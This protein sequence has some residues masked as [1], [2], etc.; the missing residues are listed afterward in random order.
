[1]LDGETDGDTS[2]DLDDLEAARDQDDI[3]RVDNIHKTYLLG[4]EGVAALR[5]VSMSVRRGEFV[6]LYGTS[7][8]GKTTLLNCI[9]TIDKPTKGHIYIG[10]IRLGEKTPESELAKLRLTKLGFVFQTFNLISS[11]TAIENVE[12]PMTLEGSLS[13]GQRRQRGI[14]L[15]TKVGMGQRLHH[16]PSQLS[17]GEQQR[18]TIARA[19]A[20]RPQILLL[21]EPTGDLDTR[22]SHIVLQMLLSLNE[23]DGITCVMVTHDMGLKTLADRVLHLR[24]GKLHRQELIDPERRRVA[25]AAMMSA[26]EAATPAQGAPAAVVPKT[27]AECR[28]TEVRRACD[29]STHISRVSRGKSFADDH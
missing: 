11:L 19:L 26:G 29:Y 18:V 20:N 25:R 16:L 24:D 8:G 13:P 5:G 22:N 23:E 10:D 2:V 4:A 27:L 28:S 1:M 12:M 3:I 6:M 21:D 7:G 15:L 14:E 17:G 9:G